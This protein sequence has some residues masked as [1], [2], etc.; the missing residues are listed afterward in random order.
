MM[1]SC[2]HNNKSLNSI[3]LIN[4][5]AAS[6]HS[7]TGDI[8]PSHEVQQVVYSPNGSPSHEVQQHISRSLKGDRFSPPSVSKYLDTLQIIPLCRKVSD[9]GRTATRV[10]FWLYHKSKVKSISTTYLALSQGWTGRHTGRTTLNLSQWCGT[11]NLLFRDGPLCKIMFWLKHRWQLVSQDR[12]DWLTLYFLRRKES[13]DLCEY[14]P[15][16]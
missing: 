2:K 15:W 10:E 16:G 11:S 1:K 7:T 12:Q 14:R 8:P 4:T 13:M 5:K 3:L 6:Q 9:I